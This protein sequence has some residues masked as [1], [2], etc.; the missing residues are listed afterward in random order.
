MNLSIVI[1]NWNS[2]EYLFRCLASVYRETRAIS[3]EVIVVDNASWDDSCAL[4][5]RGYYPHAKLFRSEENL[6]FAKASNLGFSHSSGDV[7]LFLNPDT[8]IES[9]V[10]SRMFDALTSNPEIG[11]LGP[12]LLNSDRSLQTSCVQA[13]PT[14]LNQLLDSEILRLRFP[15][16]P[17]WGMRPL[18]ESSDL[19]RRAEAVS[20][21]CL[22]ATRTAV[23]RVGAFDERYFMYVE[24]IDLCQR[25]ARSGLEVCYIGSCEVI[26]HG[27]KSSEIQSKYFVNL[28]QKDALLQFFSY[29]RGRLYSHLYRFCLGFAAILRLIAIFLIRFRGLAHTPARL[30]ASPLEKWSLILRWTLGLKV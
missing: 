10:F 29:T 26:H 7:L 25:I 19:L 30:S 2:T 12:R 22:M 18:F 17:L 1:V 20:G 6:G 4:M 16:A 14:I 5:L 27:G 13:Y 11:A 23:E 9:D 8:E 15:L 3:I 28:R 24:D 21:A